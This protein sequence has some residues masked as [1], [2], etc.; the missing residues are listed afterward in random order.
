MKLIRDFDALTCTTQEI[1]SICEDLQSKGKGKKVVIE[2]QGDRILL[3]D[4]SVNEG[5]TNIVIQ[6]EQELNGLAALKRLFLGL[7]R[8]APPADSPHRGEY[9]ETMRQLEA[10]LREKGVTL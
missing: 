1:I 7:A 4:E 8:D 2:H 5:E 6:L 3:Y 10:E 9:E